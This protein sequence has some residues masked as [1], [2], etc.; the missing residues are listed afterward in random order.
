MAGGSVERKTIC[1]AFSLRVLG[2][3]P[4]VR[5]WKIGRCGWHFGH[6]PILPLREKW[7][8]ASAPATSVICILVDMSERLYTLRRCN[9]MHARR[10]MQLHIYVVVVLCMMRR[11]AGAYIY[12]VVVL[13]MM[14]RV[15]YHF[16][17]HFAQHHHVVFALRSNISDLTVFI[18]FDARDQ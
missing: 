5:R 15:F 18:T 13:C 17:T 9:Y 7:G 3:G 16:W 2:V 6:F 10:I 8:F 11:V 14:R 1:H 12:V 4:G